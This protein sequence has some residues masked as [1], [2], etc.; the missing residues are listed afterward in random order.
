L[1][2][3]ARTENRNNAD[4]KKWSE[5]NFPDDRSGRHFKLHDLRVET[6][7]PAPFSGTGMGHDA[8]SDATLL[9]LLFDHAVQSAANPVEIQSFL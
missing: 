3:R 5:K 2:K 7:I 9:E 6:S 1:R 8:L 4:G